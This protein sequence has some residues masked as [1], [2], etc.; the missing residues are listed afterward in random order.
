MSEIHKNTS[1]HVYLDVYGGTVDETP[2]AEVVNANSDVRQ[3]VVTQETAPTGVD[4]RYSVILNMADT[5]NEGE[6][7]VSWN[8]EMDGVPVTKKDYFEIVTPILTFREIREIHP[9]ATDDEVT[10]IESAVRHIIQAHTGQ[11]FG[12]FTGVKEVRGNDSRALALPARLQSLIDVNGYEGSPT[13]FAIDADGYVLKHYSWGVPPVK[14][15]YYGLHQHTNGVIHN[16]NHVKMGQFYTTNY[17]AVNGVWGWNGVPI[18]VK[19]AAK[20]LVNDYAC[21]DI[22]YRDRYLTSMTAA[23][24]RIQFHSGAFLKTGNVRADQLLNEY[25]L[26]RGWAVI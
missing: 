23:D 5:Q 8:F 13:Y 11:T 1:Q 4:E 16:P 10:R 20:L 3:L 9:N 19:E 14:A 2:T 17:Y 18:Q 6:L 25:V 26:K 12:Q 21:G 24:W 22:Q 7:T 15:D